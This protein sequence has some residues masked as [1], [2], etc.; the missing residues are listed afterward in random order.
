MK[1]RKGTR[2]WSTLTEPARDLSPP[3]PPS[4]PSSLAG[5]GGHLPSRSPSPLSLASSLPALFL[6]LFRQCMPGPRPDDFQSCPLSNLSLSLC[7]LSHSP[8]LSGFLF[9]S[10]MLQSR[11]RPR[12]G[13]TVR[14]SLIEEN[15]PPRGGE[16]TRALVFRESSLLVFTSKMN[17]F[18]TPSLQVFFTA[19]LEGLRWRMRCKKFSRSKESFGVDRQS[20]NHRTSYNPLSCSVG[21]C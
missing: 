4:V 5:P 7:H 12:R 16:L 20:L 10:D 14:G 8:S 6:S 3:F 15:P 21:G 11:R 13:G 1:R 18:P 9:L 19:G 2:G 17:G